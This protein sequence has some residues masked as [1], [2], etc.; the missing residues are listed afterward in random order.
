[1]YAKLMIQQKLLQR[2]L[3]HF[4]KVVPITRFEEAWHL[5]LVV[6]LSTNS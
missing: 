6:K 2:I 1:M 5:V 3:K 4:G